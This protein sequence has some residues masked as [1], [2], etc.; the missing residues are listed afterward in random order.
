MQPGLIKERPRQPRS[1]VEPVGET[2]DSARKGKRAR[3][4]LGVD[5]GGTKMLARLYRIAGDGSGEV[6]AEG[7]AKASTP[8]DGPESVLDCLVDV[9]KG[10]DGWK[11]A[12]AVG[13]GVPGPVDANGVVTHCPNIVGWDD[14]IPA[15]KILSRALGKRVVVA[16]D[17]NCGAAAEH[18]VGAG[19][20]YGDLLAIFV[21]TGVGGGLI[22]D[23][24]LISG[25]RGLV[26][27]LG[28][29]LVEP[30]GRPCGCGAAGHLE[31][32]AG[33]AGM[34]AE[35]RRRAADGSS[36][37][38]VDLVGDGVIKSRH[39]AA[40]LEAEDPLTTELVTQAADALAQV[41]GNAATLL[42][43]P[44]VVIGGGLAD[45]LGQSF[46]NQISASPRF[47][48]FGSDVT[49]LK[50]A[51][52]MDDAGAVGAALLAFDSC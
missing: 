40:G 4:V 3:K 42:D 19:V 45:R 18:R 47:G 20:G 23:N 8:K 7:R 16:N 17:V 14:P 39:I 43:L 5:L 1:N 6:T 31:T 35:A 34:V 38:L 29:M 22:L 33:R 48:G 26:G 37:F 36:N 52:R 12:D 24:R 25:E 13:V 51:Q 44:L 49:E 11:S 32:Y 9:A 41:I 10:L 27:E 2:K 46:L 28:H 30:G 15:A 50:L 21:G